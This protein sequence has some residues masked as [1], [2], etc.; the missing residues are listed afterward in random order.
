MTNQELDNL[1]EELLD[2]PC[3]VIDVLPRRVPVDAGGQFA[4]VER[5]YLGP[6]R[7]DNM[8]GRIAD[9][10]LK[11]NCYYDF[12]AARDTLEGWARN[13]SP[14][15]LARWISLCV[16]ARAAAV[17]RIMVIVEETEDSRALVTLNYDDMHVTVYH[18]SDELLVLLRDLAAAS[19]LFLWEGQ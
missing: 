6:S 16:P 19:G 12:W 15:E 10:L 2:V 18:A 7:A 5:F 13:P 3:W 14:R 1:V 4:S 9:V 8:R 11:L 17:G